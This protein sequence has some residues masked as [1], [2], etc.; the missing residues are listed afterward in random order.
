ML[1]INKKIADTTKKKLLI[2]IINDFILNEKKNVLI[3][4]NN[5]IKTN[6]FS[7]AIEKIIKANVDTVIVNNTIKA[8]YSL[9]YSSR[10]NSRYQII[11]LPFDEKMAIPSY[12]YKIEKLEDICDIEDIDKDQNINTFLYSQKNPLNI[13]PYCTWSF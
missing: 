13:S 5:D 10:I 8:K 7:N 2:K 1:N 3:L 6:K 9:L 11:L 12:I 4:V